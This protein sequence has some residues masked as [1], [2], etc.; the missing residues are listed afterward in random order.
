MLLKT[1]RQGY[2]GKGQFKLTSWE[3][4]KDIW[5]TLSSSNPMIAEEWITYDREVSLIL[6]RNTAGEIILYPL[7]YNEHEQGILRVSHAPYR[8]EILEQLAEQYAQRIVADL[9]YVGVMAIEFF[10]VNNQLLVNEIA[11]RVHN[12]GHWT[13][14]GA[15]TSQFENHVRAIT[16]LPL[17]SP[18]P[19]GFSA[20]IN[21]IGHEP[22]N[23]TELLHIPGVHLHS[24]GK[25]ARPLRKLGH[26]TICANDPK[27]VSQHLKEV[28]RFMP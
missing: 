27:T 18:E 12:S 19:R 9:D 22:K 25:E 17:G 10:C 20:M 13:I 21:C 23:I 4:A 7:T 5:I 2:D 24:Y 3:Q 15:V 8:D 28:Q 14:E 16:G 1:R 26:L 6:A 11:P